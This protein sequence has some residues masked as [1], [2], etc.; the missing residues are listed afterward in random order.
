MQLLLLLTDAAQQHSDQHTAPTD[1]TCAKQHAELGRW[2]ATKTISHTISLP[3][4]Y[5]QLQVYADCSC[6][7]RHASSMQ[8]LQVVRASWLVTSRK[9]QLGMMP[10][11]APHTLNCL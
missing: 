11:V 6:D 4:Q 8:T 7:C 10:A 5:W 1:M 9:R 3:R 2:C